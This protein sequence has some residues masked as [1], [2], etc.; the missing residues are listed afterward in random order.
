MESS[1][2]RYGKSKS[3]VVRVFLNVPST[4]FM[5]KDS[6]VLNAVVFLWK[7][8]I[9]LSR[10]RRPELQSRTIL[11]VT[12]GDYGR[13]DMEQMEKRDKE[14]VPSYIEDDHRDEVKREIMEDDESQSK[15]NETLGSF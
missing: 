13:A 8:R 14:L 5:V 7:C 9:Y 4:H 10:L 1:T 15:K 12:R 6:L 11:N 2:I 3:P